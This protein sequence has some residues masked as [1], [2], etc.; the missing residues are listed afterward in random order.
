MKVI[1]FDVGIKNLAVCIMEIHNINKFSILYWDVLNLTQEYK[2]PCCCHENC[3]VKVKYT[4][5]NKYYCGR[6]A[7]KD[8]LNLLPDNLKET[9]IKKYKHDELV[10]LVNSFKIS[11][12][13][14][15][16]KKYL[17]ELLL[18]YIKNNFVLLLPKEKKASEI[19]LIDIGRE[20]N[21]KLDLLNKYGPFDNI[22]IENQISPIASRM[23][24][25]QGMIS[26]HYIMNN[27]PE[28]NFVSSSNKL[29]LFSEEKFS[30]YEKRKKASIIIS[31]NILNKNS[32]FKDFHCYLERK[33]KKDD[34]ADCFLQLLWFLL[35]NKK[36]NL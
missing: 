26:Y 3:N 28:I 8:N 34:L 36:I 22:L 7:K 25:I 11:I 17:T 10:D 9:K 30:N 24:T 35:K 2:Y 16:S 19:N 32:N 31:K 23:K 4:L 15:T 5:N 14:K 13:G 12:Q 29:N 33:G 21:K 20:M 18:E 6:H 1:S 27:C